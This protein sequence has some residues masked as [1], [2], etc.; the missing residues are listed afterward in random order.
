MLVNVSDCV[1]SGCAAALRT[2]GHLWLSVDDIIDI[3]SGVNRERT[4]CEAQPRSGESATFR[5]LFI[6]YFSDFSPKCSEVEAP[7][8]EGR[9]GSAAAGCAFRSRISEAMIRPGLRRRVAVHGPDWDGATTEP[10]RRFWGFWRF[11]VVLGCRARLGSD[12][13]AAAVAI[14]GRCVKRPAL[15]W[16]LA[17]YLLR[18]VRCCSFSCVWMRVVGLFGVVGVKC[19]AGS[20]GAAGDPASLPA[21]AGRISY[22]TQPVLL[23]TSVIQIITGEKQETEAII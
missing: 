11:W 5:L 6:F 8:R 10:V 3:V 2:S 17:E 4:G 20:H 13:A 16:L 14:W 22:T 15:L 18:G 1:S 7:Q 19:G 23:R 12:A 9:R 21:A